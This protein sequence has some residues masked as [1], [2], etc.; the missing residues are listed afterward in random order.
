MTDSSLPAFA[1]LSVEELNLGQ[2]NV[3]FEGLKKLL[4]DPGAL[5]NLKVLK[6]DKVKLP[7]NVQE[8]T[9]NRPMLRIEKK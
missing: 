2:N 5:P 4:G 9:Q 3:S 7:E 8:L 1:K 6:L